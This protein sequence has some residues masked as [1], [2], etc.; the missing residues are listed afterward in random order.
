MTLIAD[1]LLIA[2]ALTA[3]MYC[4]VLSRRLRRLRDMD[5]GV[6]AAIA[7]LSDQ[8]DAMRG[9]LA[10]ARSQSAAATRTMT[11]TTARAEAAA[12][13]LELL[14][15]AARGRP[16]PETPM[17]RA[18]ASRRAETSSA[19]TPAERRPQAPAQTAAPT[20]AA[21]PPRAAA[22]EGRTTPK[23]RRDLGETAVLRATLERLA[24]AGR[25]TAEGA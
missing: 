4:H 24:G 11:E 2:A 20:V 10:A 16:T 13:R 5:G 12:A 17:Q 21:E 3:A 15:A 22:A 6:G 9:A 23:R 8:V 18:V 7:T 19:F 25:P 1:G 14:I